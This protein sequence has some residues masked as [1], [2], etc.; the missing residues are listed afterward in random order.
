MTD[1]D[2]ETPAT[3]DVRNEIETLIRKFYIDSIGSIIFIDDE[4]PTLET[5][6]TKRNGDAAAEAKAAAG[7]QDPDAPM[8]GN[9]AASADIDTKNDDVDNRVFQLVESSHK[10]GLLV[11][12]LN[13]Y[14]ADRD[15][16]KRADLLVLD[17]MIGGSP[18]KTVEALREL[19]KEKGFKPILIYTQEDVGTAAEHV[20]DAL[21]GTDDGTLHKQ[22]SQDDAPWTTYRN[23]FIVFI[24][25]QT[26]SNEVSTIDNLLEKLEI[27]LRSHS[28]SPMNILAWV[29]AADLRRNIHENIDKMLPTREDKAS[30][31]FAAICNAEET[32]SREGVLLALDKILGVLFRKASSSLSEDTINAIAGLLANIGKECENK[33][34]AFV[35]M[36]ENAFGQQ[37]GDPYDHLNKFICNE[38]HIP[39]KVTTGTIFST[40]DSQD[41]KSN[42]Y[43]CVSPECDLARETRKKLCCVE[44]TTCKSKP[45]DLNSNKYILFADDD[46]VKTASVDPL[47]VRTHDFF[48]VET[49]SPGYYKLT[50]SE[51]KHLP[52]TYEATEIKILAQLRPEY[53]HRLMA[54]V[55]AWHSRIGLD[56]IEKPSSA[57]RTPNAGR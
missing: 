50:L 34:F 27:A 54:R 51:S 30:A 55:G 33:G 10:K 48:L 6:L 19:S 40:R 16:W 46:G 23:L 37:K 9:R 38:P 44:L 22:M 8:F 31:L 57:A 3:D 42:Y 39:E 7:M 17:Y 5:L 1:K 35:Q 18:R 32:Q 36:L 11:D 29:I 4:F 14:P 56:F 20:H 15:F 13:D 53:A 41:G 49:P 25:K 26:F 21:H 47:R 28:P 2:P 43:V 12:I 24:S 45:R 52:P